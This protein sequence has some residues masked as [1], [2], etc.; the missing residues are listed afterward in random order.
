MDIWAHFEWS[1][2]TKDVELTLNTLGDYNLTNEGCLIL[3]WEEAL[4][5]LIAGETSRRVDNVNPA[6]LLLDS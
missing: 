6:R 2:T 3:M 4:N 1:R 5:Y